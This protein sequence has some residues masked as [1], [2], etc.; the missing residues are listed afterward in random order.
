M[1]GKQYLRCHGLGVPQ[2]MKILIAD[3]KP[4]M[5]RVIRGL[6]ESHP[7]WEVGEAEDGAQAVAR[8]KQ[9][10]PD[11]VVLDLAMPELNGFEAARQIA[12]AIPGVPIFLNTLYASP[13]VEREAERFGVQRVISKS[14]EYQLV[15]AIEE[16]LG[17][18]TAL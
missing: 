14:E 17:T 2:Q 10:K 9:D 6:L 7:G 15:P 3:D 4:H 13:Q 11:V 8:A 1:L 12:N 18:A 16:V 5:R